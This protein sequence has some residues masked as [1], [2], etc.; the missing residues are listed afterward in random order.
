[1]RRV[2]LITLVS[3]LALFLGGCPGGD[4]GDQ[5]ANNTPAP[6]PVARKAPPRPSPAATPTTPTTPFA[7]PLTA[8]QPGKGTAVSGLVQTLPPEQ[9]VKQ[10]PKGRVDPFAAIPLVPEVYVSPNTSGG[11]GTG[12]ARPVPT[13]SPLPPL[14]PNNR[15]AGNQA[16][17][18]RVPT[19]PRVS[20][21]P[22]VPTAPRTNVLPPRRTPQQNL[23]PPS[24]VPPRPGT[25]NVLPPV[26]PPNFRP[27]LPQLPEP[28][29]AQGVEVTGV[30]EVGGV[31]NAI[32]TVPNEPSRYV[33][34]GQRLS[35]GQVLVKR[36]DMNRGPTPVV[37]LEQYGIEVAREVGEKP[38][39][40]PGR[41]RQPGSP[42]AFL[43]EPSPV[44]RS[45]PP[46]A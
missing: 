38:Q 44:N 45:L 19:G 46:Q 3:V 5:S 40:A 25:G 12:G 35:N 29:L 37:I 7:N 9:R 32:V 1:M 4:G 43:P 34:A 13:I 21:A 18:P 36:I 6:T 15:G 14:R 39:T 20:T 27:E 10:I 28:T 16:T 24:S 26:S 23:K 11:G 17:R 8:Q 2:S 33:Q 30:V 22:R 31:P 42:T 41:P